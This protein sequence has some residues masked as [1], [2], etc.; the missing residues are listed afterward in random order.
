MAKSRLQMRREVEAADSDSANSKSR[1]KGTKKKATRK[2]AAPRKAREKTPERKR[3]V[4]IVYSGSMKEEG[5]FAY[6]QKAVA[7][8]RL[9]T[10]L[11][12]GKKL[13]F[14]QLVKELISGDG[15]VTSDTAPVPE[16]GKSDDDEFEEA[17]S[18]TEAME[19]ADFDADIDESDDEDEDEIEDDD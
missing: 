6:D 2:K 17:D 7:E 13:Y 1:A 16:S 8:E 9:E 15:P 10:L 12:R 18:K 11:N 3:A 19:D 5:R 14:L 4:W